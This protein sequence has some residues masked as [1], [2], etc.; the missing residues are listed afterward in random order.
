[1]KTL[2]IYDLVPEETK[3]VIVEMT[4]DEYNMFSKAN[5]VYVNASDDEDGIDAVNVISN[6]FISKD[7]YLKYCQ[8]DT[9]RKYFGKW[10][11]EEN[12]TDISEVDKLIHCGFIL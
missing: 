6:A 8:T 11:P 2:I 1:M 3:K 10:I 5:G 9:E 12:I 4:N 7:E